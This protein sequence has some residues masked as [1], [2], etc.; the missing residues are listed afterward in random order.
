VRSL[1]WQRKHK[2]NKDAGVQTEGSQ[3]VEARDVETWDDEVQEA[4]SQEARSQ[5]NA[6]LLTPQ[7]CCA[8]RL[9]RELAAHQGKLILTLGSESLKAIAHILE[10]PYGSQKAAPGALHVAPAKKQHGAPIPLPDGRILLA[11]LHPAFT[12]SGNS[13]FSGVVRADIQRAA[14]VATRGFI[15]WAEPESILNPTRDVVLNVLHILRH[16]GT[17]LTVDI[18]TDGINTQTCKIRCVGIATTLPG[19]SP[20]AGAGQELVI[21]V[22]LRHT[23]GSPWWS[24]GDETTINNALRDVLENCHLS[25]H[26]FAFDSAVLLNHGLMRNRKKLWVDT[27]LL[28][29]STRNAELLHDLGFVATRYFEVPRWKDDADHKAHDNL[30]DFWLH[31]YCG[32]DCLLTMRLV[33]PLVADVERDDGFGAYQTDSKLA[34]IVRDMGDLGLHIDESRRYQHFKLLDEL[35]VQRGKEV[36]RI[37][38]DSS[39]NPNASKQVAKYLFITK[40]LSP[41]FST[42]GQD[43]AELADPDAEVP[44]DINDPDIILSEATTGEMALVKLLDLGVDAETNAFIE[45]LL[46]YRGL[47]KCTSTFLGYKWQEDRKGNRTLVDT[48][49]ARKFILDEQH[50]G[51]GRLS[52]LHPSWR[53][54][55]TQCVTLDTWVLTQHGPRR[56]GDLPGFPATKGV[57]PTHGLKLHDG[58]AMQSVSHLVNSGLCEALTVKTT[59]GFKLTG[60][61]HHRVIRGVFRGGKTSTDGPR[62]PGLVGRNRKC[63]P[64]VPKA[65]WCRLDELCAGDYVQ[66]SVGQNVWSQT[67]PKLVIRPFTRK[68]TSFKKDIKIPTEVTLELAEFVGMYTADGSL[69]DANGSFSIRISNSKP[70]VMRRAKQL[71][72]HL[73]GASRV[74]QDKN[75]TIVTSIA[76]K[77][78]AEDVGLRRTVSNKRAP[79]WV[80]ASPREYVLAYIRG[81]ALDSSQ[82]MKSSATPVWRYCGTHLLCEEMQML[83]L[84]FGI[85]ASFLDARTPVYENTAFCLVYGKTDVETMCA[86]TGQTPPDI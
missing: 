86:I 72:S 8:P 29:K 56:V 32:S 13:D 44:V 84:N 38:G 35:T 62:L 64:V 61:P 81:C 79:D 15:N 76:L 24:P 65:E 34:P 23:D 59:S 28:N 10:L 55:S 11:S 53:V 66:L 22:P 73:F 37:V 78:W 27:M 51:Y 49:R 45:A 5:D 82:H 9:A 77:S 26:N 47:R 74:K 3:N 57:V 68:N 40:G 33:P 25:G 6:P 41:P 19:A 1:K 14:T 63:I 83:L 18:E 16:A 7:A 36:Q 20:G 52:I 85:V 2:G 21:V 46:A 12:A 17:L 54:A 39:F 48:H 58:T 71:M 69:H 67:V 31:R 43:W 4:R 60:T 42:D 70:H 80:L 50:A 30:N 75:T